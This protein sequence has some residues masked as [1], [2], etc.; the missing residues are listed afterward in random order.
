[1]E[2]QAPAFLRF[3]LRLKPYHLNKKLVIMRKQWELVIAPR[4]KAS[5]YIR[6]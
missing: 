3:L 4:G 6:G 1:M 2:M 5:Y